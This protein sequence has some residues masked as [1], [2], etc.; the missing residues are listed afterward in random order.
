MGYDISMAGNDHQNLKNVRKSIESAIEQAEE[1]YKKKLLQ[2]RLD[3]ARSGLNAFQ[4]RQVTQA[5]NFFHSYL[6][7]LEDAKNVTEGGLLPTCFDARKE[8][9]EL[10]MVSG[11]YWDLVKLYDRTESSAKHRE[12]LHYL[13]KYIVFSKGM[14]YQALCAETLRKYISNEKPRHREE[15]KNAYRI[16]AKPRC[17]VATSLVDVTSDKTLP[18]LRNFRDQVLIQTRMGRFF[19]DWYY[20]NGPSFAARVDQFPLRVRKVLGMSLDLTA[21]ILSP[22]KNLMNQIS[23]SFRSKSK[24]T[25]RKTDPKR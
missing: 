16:L 20:E 22:K 13:E 25:I 12:F 6:Q 14:P 9:P 17:F 18:R 8:L 21:W 23:N 4:N 1:D 19:I 2:H 15:F 7:I 5:V 24:L 11:V 3:L 10:L